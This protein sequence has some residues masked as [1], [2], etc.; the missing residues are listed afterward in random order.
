MSFILKFYRFRQRNNSS[1]LFESYRPNLLRVRKNHCSSTSNS[2]K[3]LSSLID[4]DI[5]CVS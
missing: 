5:L 3:D 4:F 2:Y 1:N